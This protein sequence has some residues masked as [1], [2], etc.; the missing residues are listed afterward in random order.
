[1]VE[2]PQRAA[3]VFEC[4]DMRINRKYLIG[5]I[6]FRRVAGHSLG[7]CYLLNECWGANVYVGELYIYI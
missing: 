3:I 6:S 4:T 7:E 1:M 2:A 5:T